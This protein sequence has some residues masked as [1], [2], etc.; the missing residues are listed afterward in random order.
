MQMHAMAA[1]CQQTF[2]LRVRRSDSSLGGNALEEYDDD[3][4]LTLLTCLSS[5]LAALLRGGSCYSQRYLEP[6]DLNR[7]IKHF[8]TSKSLEYTSMSGTYHYPSRW[9]QSQNSLEPSH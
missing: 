7:V 8:M 4:M 5:S 2:V 1:P 9:E 6:E 3:Q